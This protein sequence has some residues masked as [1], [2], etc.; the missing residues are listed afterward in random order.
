MAT[1]LPIRTV[2]R[3]TCPTMPCVGMSFTEERDGTYYQLMV[4]YR[5]GFTEDDG[6]GYKVRVWARAGDKNLAVR[7]LWDRIY[8]TQ[9]G[10][11]RV[12]LRELTK[13]G[14][15]PKEGDETDG[16]E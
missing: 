10:A 5:I 11:V 3:S 4:A 1:P 9:R 13:W 6:P 8:K 14:W 2:D 7:D 15:R 16:D 12:G